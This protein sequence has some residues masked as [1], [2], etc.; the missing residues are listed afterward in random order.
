MTATVNEFDSTDS[1]PPSSTSCPLSSPRTESP[2]PAEVNTEKLGAPIPFNDQV[3]ECW[4]ICVH[5]VIK[6]WCRK[7]PQ[8]PAVV[9]WDGTFTYDEVDKLSDQL[10]SAL[11]LLS[12]GPETFVPIC[13]QKSRWTTIAMLGVMKTGGAFCLL[14]P[15]HP[16]PRLQTICEE[17][18]SPVLLSC[19]TQSGRCMQICNVIVVEH[20]CQAWHPNSQMPQPSVVTNPASALYV[21]FTSGS[22]GKPKGAVID[23]CAYASGAREHVKVF[24]IDQGSRVLQFSSY[25]FDVCIMETLSTLMVGACLCVIGSDQRSD[26]LV[27]A[28]AMRQLEVSHAL[29]TPSFARTVPWEVTHLQTLVLGGEEMRVSD[30]VIGV[31]KDINIINAYGMSECSVNATAQVRVQPEGDLRC[32]GHPTGAVAWVIEPD[33]PERQV[34]P[35]LVGELL[36]EGPIVGRGYLNDP[37][38]TSRAFIEPPSWLKAIREHSYQHRLYRTGDLVVQDSSGNITLLGRKDGQVKIRGHRIEVAGIEDHIK[39]V[40]P[41]AEEVIVAKVTTI[42]DQRDALMAFVKPEQIYG[43]LYEDSPLFLS[44]QMALVAEFRAAQNRLQ[45]RVPNYMIPS[46][47]LA[48]AEIPR[49]LSGKVDRRLLQTTAACFSREQLQGLIGSSISTHPPRGATEI[50]L[51]KLYSQFLQLPMSSVGRD[52][53]FVYLGG[54][55]IL[56]LRLV[57]AAREAGLLLDIRDV[58]GT[59]SLE[60][61]ARTATHVP[62]SAPCNAYSPFSL[63]DGQSDNNAEIMRLAQEQCG[64]SLSDIEDIYPCTP[65]QEGMISLSTSQPQ[66]YTGSILFDM[67]EDVDISDFKA[68]WESVVNSSPILRTRIIQTPQGLLQVVVRGEIPWESYTCPTAVDSV[69]SSP[70]APLIRFALGDGD[71]RGEFTITV[72]HALWDAWSMQLIVE[73]IEQALK[74]R[75]LQIHHFYPFIQYLQELDDSM[76]DFWRNE[77]AGLD[78]PTFPALPMNHHRPA[79]TGVLQYT[80][81]EIDICSRSHTLPTYIH[82]AWS[83]LVAHYTDSKEVVYGCTISGRNAPIEGINDMVGPTIATVPIRTSLCPQGTISSALDQIQTL[84]TRMIPFEQAGL[85]RIAKTSEDAARACGFQSHLNIQ[86]GGQEQAH[87]LCPIKDGSASSGID[88]TKFANY[89]INIMLQVSPDASRITVDMA[90]DPQVLNAWEAE[91]MVAQWEHILRQLCH[92]PGGTL[93]DLDFTSARDKDLLRQWNAAV[94]EADNRCLHDLVLA[95]QNRHGQK[96]AISAWDGDFTYR[97]LIQM[98]SSF[99]WRLNLLAIGPGSF[100]AVC[101]ERNRWSIVAILAI[102]QAGGTCVLL[103]PNHPRQRMERIVASVSAP[104]AIVDSSTA[105]AARRLAPIE[106]CVSEKFKDCLWS[107]RDSDGTEHHI[108]VDPNE[109]AFVIFTSGTTGEPKA[110]AMPHR[111]VSSSIKYHST[112]MG[113]KAAT[114]ALHFSS[115]AFDVSIYE[116]F[117]TLAAGGCICVPS[118]SERMNELTTF[119]QRKAVDWAFLTPSVAQSLHPSEVP[120]L[121]TLVLGG[122]AAGVEHVKAW[123]PGRSLINGYGPAEATICAVGPLP[124]HGWVPGTIGHVVGGLGWITTPNDPTQ[125]AA[126]GAV[127]ELLLE[128]PFL[129]R[130]YL[131]QI[132]ATAAS[133]IQP[134][135]WR[136]YSWLPWDTKT[137]RLYRTG[138]LVRYQENGTICYIGR[139][140]TQVKLRGQRIDLDGIEGQ[141]HRCFSSAY[142]VVVDIVSLP[143]PENAKLLVAF[144]NCRQMSPTEK[145][146][147]SVEPSFQQAISHAKAQLEPILPTYMVPTIFVPVNHFP[148]TFVGKLDRRRLHQAVIS[149]SPH[150]LQAYRF[151]GDQ[152]MKTPVT[153]EDERRLQRIWAGLLHLPCDRIGSEDTFL[154]HG[155]DSVTAMRL[156]ALASHANFTFTVADVLN[157]RPLSQLARTCRIST[158]ESSLSVQKATSNGD[159]VAQPKKPMV[160]S[161]AYMVYHA[162]QAQSSL[163]ERYP[164]THWQFSFHGEVDVN[165]LQTACAGLV[166]A[167]SILRTVFTTVN[168]NQLFQVVLDHMDL[169]T[170]CESIR[171]KEQSENVLCPE[172]PAR[173]TL[174]SDPSGTSHVFLLRLSHAQYDGVCVPNILAD[175][176][177]LYEGRGPVT[178]TNFEQYQIHRHLYD[179][180][181]AVEFWQDYLLCAPAPCTMPVAA[182]ASRTPCSESARACTIS[183]LQTVAFGPV[184]PQVTL[185]T[186]V[187]AAACLVLARITGHAD[188]TIGQTVN[189][190]SLPVPWIGDIAGPCLNYI[191]FRASFE[192]S[193]TVKDYLQYIQK[194]HNRCIGYAGTELGTIIPHCTS[195]PPTTEFGFIHQHQDVDMDLSLTLGANRSASQTSFGRLSP[196]NEVWICSTPCLPMVDIEIIASSRTLCEDAAQ[197]LADNISRTMQ[198]LLDNLERPVGDLEAIVEW[199]V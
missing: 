162:T 95:Q 38:A 24:Q 27:F 153:T 28:D 172:I 97:E 45:E 113:F 198:A 87:R 142:D 149:L 44:P 110:I 184:P 9:A 47:F 55:S 144:I 76:E 108:R 86:T 41:A 52:S 88:L 186:M 193:M 104:L 132:D 106:L 116:I 170:H 194:Q 147:L 199:S 33:D 173:F 79:P 65:L 70:G 39:Q 100:V 68:A 102:L 137:T 30:A 166:A 92:Q 135:L 37:E 60:E 84:M 85:S 16:L 192:Q 25:A 31:E 156:V 136:R 134:P 3:P 171:D 168:E 152:V 13:M 140:D 164:W 112:G 93:Q 5:D 48:V 129:A 34:S 54:D 101:M 77:M 107:D 179:N 57:A 167:H 15:S 123:A 89:A 115:Y 66:M 94:P 118:E 187:K 103:E 126:V 29:L 61:V 133:F 165:Q 155:G 7:T 46:F 154:L 190:R 122:E 176:E 195:W 197:S 161:D 63:L 177:A 17:L 175:L 64:V 159:Q 185:A 12:V 119:I 120:S 169:E 138:D 189:T 125:L 96:I 128:G 35:G 150:E 53:S 83:L 51:Q 183:A 19:T 157:N 145:I 141:L 36:L 81:K 91:Q 178:P 121:S 32:I 22:T 56:V 117:T 58:L 158:S 62:S 67:P 21:A 72:H 49:T 82:L 146:L 196:G 114:R 42:S 50:T 99:A 20:L 78:A 8:S 151:T 14:D 111:Q 4:D 90:Y 43:G 74:G 174:V 80:V 1:S 11:T 69:S 143:A 181:H 109:L 71:L 6:N 130:G 124:E 180:K 73:D 10:A 59:A 131:N 23:H 105:S 139:R 26:V 127:G 182:P 75:A 160:E 98:T 148:K 188:V 163:I 191:P 40:L 18:S 2:Q